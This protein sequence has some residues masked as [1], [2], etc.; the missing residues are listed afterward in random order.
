MLSLFIIYAVLTNSFH[1]ITLVH[2]ASI[3]LYCYFI[4][5]HFVLGATIFEHSALVNVHSMVLNIYT[6]TLQLM[7]AF[8]YF[9]SVVIVSV[10]SLILVLNCCLESTART[11]KW[12]C[13][14]DIDVL[15]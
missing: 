14:F 7:Y 9:S 3:C 12:I 8:Y 2:E 11:F 13:I 5:I 6:S 4:Y 10:F 1:V 15:R